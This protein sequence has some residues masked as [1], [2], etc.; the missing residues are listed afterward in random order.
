VKL[1]VE[2]VWLKL[3]STRGTLFTSR[4]DLELRMKLVKCYILSM[5]LCG[6]KTWTI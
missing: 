3:H 6:A 5:A 1:N 4:L 2:L